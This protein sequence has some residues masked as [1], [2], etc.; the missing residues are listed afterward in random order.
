MTGRSAEP[1]T[2][3]QVYGFASVVLGASGLVWHDFARP[4]EIGPWAGFL[5]AFSM[6]VPLGSLPTRSPDRRPSVKTN[7]ARL[8]DADPAGG[9][10]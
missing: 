6:A 4:W 8:R 10:R 5:Q 7:C 3:A 2:G 9:R 1:G